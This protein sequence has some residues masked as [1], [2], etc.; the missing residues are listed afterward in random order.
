MYDYLIVGAG[1]F[2]SVFAHVMKEVGKNC[3]VI[4]KRNHIG[5]NIYTESID[6]IQ[7]HKYGPHIFHTSDDTIW[8]FI[9]RFAQFNRFT[10]SPLAVVNGKTYNLPFNMNTF[11]QVWGIQ[12]P[13]EA[14]SFISSQLEKSEFRHPQN[15]EQ[16]AMS[17][18]G[19]QLYEMF[20]K[21]Y[22]EK[23]WGRKCNELP[24]SI[25]KRIPLR[26]DFDNNY[27]NDKYQGVP[28]GGYTQIIQKLLKGI[29][30][31][32]NVDFFSDRDFFASMAKKIVYTGPIDRFFNFSHGKLE[33]RSL[34]FELEYF[35][36]ENYQGNA[37]INY[38]DR[39]I[40]Y[41]RVIEHK[42]FEFG[43]QPNTIISREFPAEFNGHN[44]PFYPI[45]D[46]VNNRRYNQ[47]FNEGQKLE[48][49]IFGGRLAEYKY[50]DMHQIVA[51]ALKKTQKEISLS[52]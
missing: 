10:N 25:I 34:N 14:Q 48:N 7:I 49:L 23:Q 33:Y 39:E 44:E 3:L 11:N 28:I 47:Y 38:C 41:T 40:P 43:K 9:N 24:P 27:F 18:I 17:M 35:E 46:V 36:K 29:E 16:K 20:I 13:A 42:K 37:V 52:L 45:N 8:N 22:T 1:L 30:V 6:G 51:S 5:G 31:R 32:T 50:Y 15:L 4:E 2:G 19:Q 26:F 21:G 12:Q